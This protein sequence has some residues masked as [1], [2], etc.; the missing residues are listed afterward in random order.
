MRKRT[1]L[2]CRRGCHRWKRCGA[3]R[4]CPSR[5][6][7]VSRPFEGRRPFVRFEQCPI[8]TT[9]RTDRVLLPCHARS[10]DTSKHQ[11]SSDSE[12]FGFIVHTLNNVDRSHPCPT[13]VTGLYGPDIAHNRVNDFVCLVQAAHIRQAR[14]VAMFILA[15]VADTVQVP[16]MNL[17]LNTDEAV[18]EELRKK[19]VDRVVRGSG[20]CVA[21]Y[22]LHRIQ[23]G[24]IFPGDGAVHFNVEFRVVG[25]RRNRDL[26]SVDIT[27]ELT[28][29]C[30]RCSSVPWSERC[31]RGNWWPVTREG[32][33]LA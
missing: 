27:M 24:E 16:P 30:A 22:D 12:H 6:A 23:G 8:A 7:N 14:A 3:N 28:R 19:Y 18:L 17:G 20:L 5:H 10:F 33:K 11:L 25:S 15:R 32:C 2:G 26:K 29:S 9:G 1:C 13:P 21:I 4:H 31:W